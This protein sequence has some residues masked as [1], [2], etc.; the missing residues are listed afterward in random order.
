MSI[1]QTVAESGLRD[2]KSPLG[3]FELPCGYLDEEGVL[4]R[5]VV[6]REM[7]GDEED[8]LAS[9]RVK[10]GEKMDL[11]IAACLERLGSI[12]DKRQIQNLTGEFLIGDRLFLLYAIRRVSLGDEYPFKESCPKCKESTLY[13]FDLAQL[14]V[15]QMPNPIQRRFEEELPSGHKVVWHP[16]RGLDQQKRRR[17]RKMDILT[18]NLWVRLDEINGVR[19]TTDMLKALSSRDR[20]FLRGR[21]FQVEGGVETTV[22]VVCPLCDYEF[23]REVEIGRSGFFFPS[24]TRESWKRRRSS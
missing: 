6:V 20:D 2:P 4:H 5:E 18:L 19:P 16:M 22:E 1:A 14:E 12:T 21:F 17:H 9:R 13:P 8:I 10:D 24:E 3:S 7:T 23:E 11:L 15:V